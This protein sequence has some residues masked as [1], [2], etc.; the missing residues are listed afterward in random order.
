MS[1]QR[2]KTA[3][4]RALA[5]EATSHL[6]DRPL[7]LLLSM[8]ARRI[9]DTVESRR[10][11]LTA[12]QR[13]PHAEAFLWGHT[14]AVTRAVFS[15]DGQTVLSAG[16]DDR[17]ILWRVSTR[18]PIGQPVEGPKSLVGVAFNPDGSQFA[19]AGS[20]SVVIWDTGSRQPV[21]APFTTDRK[22]QFEKV[23]SRSVGNCLPPVRPPLAVTRLRWCCGMWPPANGSGSRSKEPASPSVPMILCWRSHDIKNWFSTIFAPIDWSHRPLNG[24]PENITSVAFSPDGTTVATGSSDKTIVL[25]DV[26]AT[27]ALGTLSGTLRN[28]DQLAL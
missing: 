14:D 28:R 8:E 19:S 20:A 23:V 9:A 1:Y 3:A 18:Q 4:S 6:D 7:A 2:Q 26:Q 21:G 25:W 22:E 11:L 27:A 10:S 15:P 5:S 12:L 16:W 17:M 24:H 13:V